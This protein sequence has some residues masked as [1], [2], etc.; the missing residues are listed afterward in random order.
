MHITEVVEAT[1]KQMKHHFCEQCAEGFR[2]S[3]VVQRI[4]GRLPMIKLRVTGASPQHTV[5][6]VLGG[7]FDG[8]TWSFATA[9]LRRLRIEPFDGEAFEVQ[10]DQAYIEWL[11]GNRD[12]PL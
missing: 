11:K 2:Q 5:L 1:A 7:R 4:F 10:D 8:E 9:R 6:T 3:D 12:S